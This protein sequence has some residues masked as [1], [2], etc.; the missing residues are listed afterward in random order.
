MNI[1]KYNNREL[2]SLNYKE[3][4]IYDKRSYFQYYGT[5]LLQKHLILFTFCPDD[6][7]LYSIKILLGFTIYLF[8]MDCITCIDFRKTLKS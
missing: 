7:N 6:Y 3:A 5:L 1:K 2:N 4:L 8:F